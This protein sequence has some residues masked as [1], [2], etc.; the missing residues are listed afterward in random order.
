MAKIF[1]ARVDEFWRKE[2]KFAYLEEHGHRGNLAWQEL[3]PDAKHTWITEGLESEFDTFLA[4]G[5]KEAKAGKATDVEAIFKTYSLGV[6]TN[7]D[8]VVYDFDEIELLKRIEQFCDEY[9]F[10]VT[11]YQRKS[12]TVNIDDFL[13]YDR[14]K[15]SRNLKRELRNQNILEFDR[16]NIRVGMYRP[17][18]KKYLYFSDIIIDELGKSKLFFPTSKTDENQLICVGG[19]GR[20]AFSVFLSN[21]IPNLN[22]YADPAQ[23]FPFYT[24]NEDGMNRRENITDWALEKFRAQFNDKSITKWDVFH[25]VYAVLHHPAYRERYAANL[26]REL[27]RIP[28]APPPQLS[29]HSRSGWAARGVA[30]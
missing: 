21:C 6:S 13:Q 25:Y 14:I 18:T 2:Q 16:G 1:Y 15:W 20:K 4:I 12:K 3:K 29:C 22:F 7:R 17:F 30:C 27:P 9:N 24:Y 28:Y 26:K 10:E 11:R 5:T 23:C 19:Y 8:D